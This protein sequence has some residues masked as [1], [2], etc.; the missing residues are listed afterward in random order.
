MPKEACIY[1]AKMRDEQRG[2]FDMWKWEQQ[3]GKGNKCTECAVLGTSN[4]Y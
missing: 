4:I 3:K 1:F 2:M